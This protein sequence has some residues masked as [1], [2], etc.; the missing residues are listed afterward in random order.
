MDFLG[1][2]SPIIIGVEPNHY[3]KHISN[4]VSVSLIQDTPEWLDWR[5][6]RIGASDT[7]KILGLSTHG[8]MLDVFIEKV[9]GS[10]NE[11]TYIQQKG[12]EIE[13]Q[14]RAN[15]Q[16]TSDGDFPKACKEREFL[17]ASADGWNEELKVGLEMKFTGK[18]NMG[19]EIRPDFYTQCQQL[20]WVYEA[21]YWI[22]LR[23]TDGINIRKDVIELDKR[24]WNKCMTKLKKFNERV[25]KYRNV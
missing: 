14:I 13:E 4:S 12:H 19:E 3:K 2:D 21:K 16:I 6:R 15:Y 17:A 1:V 23:S 11:N 5:R 25:E 10:V 7:P 22:L 18:D 9:Y 24:Y 8:D 20:I